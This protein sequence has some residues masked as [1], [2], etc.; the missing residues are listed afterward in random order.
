M[1]GNAVTSAGSPHHYDRVTIMAELH[2]LIPTPVQRRLVLTLL[3]YRWLGGVWCTE[4][5]TLT[6][7]A[8]DDMDELSWTTFLDH[9]LTS[10]TSAN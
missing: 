3:G 7:Q 8:I 2:H 5:H 6:E 10:A 4:V 1:T 9:W